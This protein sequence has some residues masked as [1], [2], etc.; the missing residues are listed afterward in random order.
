MAIDNVKPDYN[1]PQS[2]L[3]ALGDTGVSLQQRDTPELANYGIDDTYM[4]S[5]NDTLTAA[6][7]FP[8]DAEYVGA[9]KDMGE[10]KDFDAQNLRIAIRSMMS[11]VVNVFPVNSG[12]W[13]RFNTKGLDDMTDNELSICGHRVARMAQLFITQLASKGVTTALITELHTLSTK[14]SESVD[15][16]HDA[17][18]ERTAATNDRIMLANKLYAMI[19]EIFGY[20]KDYWSS[21]NYAKYKAYVIY[22]THDSKPHLSGKVGTAS[23]TML[24]AQSNEPTT[25]PKIN[26]E[27]IDAAIVPNAEGNWEIADVPI[28][29]S[30]YWAEADAHPLI[31]GEIT[32]QENQNTELNIL[33]EP[34]VT[35][36][37]PDN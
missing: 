7:N 25:N 23:G 13:A 5:F 32:I 17:E 37:P 29:C 30:Q 1:M 34:G 24:D 2:D 22:N 18:L 16:H 15:K 11:R 28:E 6:R 3:M 4:D 35:P 36:P 10:T 8:S 19:V 21:R 26:L 31:H 27:F 33:I 20:G 9:M 12:K 14:L